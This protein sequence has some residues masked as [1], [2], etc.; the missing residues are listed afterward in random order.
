MCMALAAKTPRTG[1]PRHAAEFYAHAHHLVLR[2]GR[3]LLL[4]SLLAA[5]VRHPAQDLAP[6]ANVITPIR[7]N[8]V[9]LTWGYYNG[10]LNFGGTV[11]IIGATGSYNGPVISLYHTLSFFGRSANLTAA[12]PYGVGTFQGAVLGTERSVYRSGLLD[13]SF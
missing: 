5:A 4:F 11:P 12:L 1:S 13:A 3:V 2:L 7:T 9:T 10:G 6:R 8:A